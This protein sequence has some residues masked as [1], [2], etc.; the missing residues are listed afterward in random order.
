VRRRHAA[1]AA[2]TRETANGRPWRFD[3]ED[4]GHTVSVGTLWGDYK[5]LDLS[6]GWNKGREDDHPKLPLDD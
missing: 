2:A 1:D 5:A 6:S 4:P 3:P